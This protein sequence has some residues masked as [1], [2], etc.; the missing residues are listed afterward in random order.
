[1]IR[2]ALALIVIS[3]CAKGE[4][5][6]ADDHPVPAMS[7]AEI[8]RSHDACQTYVDRVC[9][10]ADKIPAAQEPCKLS[11]ALPDAVR[12]SLEVAASPDSGKNDVLGAQAS[13]RRT[14]K[15]CIEQTAKLPALGCP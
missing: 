9:A 6:P 5:P 3:A 12:L 7:A 4:A 11:R 14:V 8:Q 2:I 1:V 10:C 13:V 15:T